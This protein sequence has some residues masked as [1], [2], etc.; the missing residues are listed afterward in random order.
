[1]RLASPAWTAIELAAVLD[2]DELEQ[3]MASA[4]HTKLIHPSVLPSVINRAE[5]LLLNLLG[6][7]DLPLPQTEVTARGW[8][9]MRI[10]W[11][12]LEDTPEAVVA[13]IAQALVS[14]RAA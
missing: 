13:R 12:R 2:Q 8:R 6:R 1:M 10:T 5:R 14:L 7:A 9:V 4:L 3:T 11:R